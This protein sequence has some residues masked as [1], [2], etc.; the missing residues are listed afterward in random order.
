MKLKFVPAILALI[1]LVWF[2][3][4][5]FVNLGPIVQETTVVTFRAIGFTGGADTQ[6]TVTPQRNFVDGTPATT[7]TVPSGR[8]LHLQ[9]FCVGVTNA[10]AAVQGIVARLRVQPA[11]AST[12]SSP[13][14]ATVGVSTNVAT[15]GAAN[16]ACIY[17]GDGI[18][19][20]GANQLGISA[21]G[22][23]LAGFDAVITGYERAL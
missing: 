5:A 19:L 11:A 9:T 2:A 13:L 15:A 18:E 1:G 6:L 20:S 21:V 22:S 23:A 7:L 10:G 14:V 8:L 4:A 12:V 16:A 17:L 3:T